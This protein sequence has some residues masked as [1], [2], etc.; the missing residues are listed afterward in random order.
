LTPILPGDKSVDS[1][2][3]EGSKG[4]GGLVAGIVIPLLL[5]LCLGVLLGWRTH[6]AK[7]SALNE[8]E[9]DMEEDVY[10]SPKTSVASNGDQEE[11]VHDDADDHSTTSSGSSSTGG[12]GTAT[13]EEEEYNDD[14]TSSY[15]SQDSEEIYVDDEDDDFDQERD[16]NSMY[17]NKSPYGSSSKKKERQQKRKKPNTN[18][19]IGGGD[20]M[21]VATGA[22]G[23]TGM[24]SV[25]SE[26]TVKMKNIV[27]PNIDINM[28]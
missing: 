13:D 20:E 12:E 2:S 17:G 10:T 6:Q 8:E 21:S 14:G 26:R 15:S 25:A 7:K 9:L 5:V 27:L 11:D 23:A 3:T 22:T 18:I 24:H 19:V 1:S 16:L 28:R 4:N